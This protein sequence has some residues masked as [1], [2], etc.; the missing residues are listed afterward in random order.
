MQRVGLTRT[1]RNKEADMND[2]IS[3]RDWVVLVTGVVVAS[4]AAPEVEGA[5]SSQQSAPAERCPYF[6]Q[7]LLCKGKKYC[8]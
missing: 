8:Q 3:R 5:E 1:D 7:A 4:I 2:E 6:D